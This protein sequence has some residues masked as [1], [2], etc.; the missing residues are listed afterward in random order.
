MG[1]GGGGGKLRISELKTLTMK[2]PIPGLTM[3]RI[4]YCCYKVKVPG[5]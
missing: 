1:R 3:L 2:I 5:L 4:P